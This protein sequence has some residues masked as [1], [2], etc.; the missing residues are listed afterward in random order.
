MK[1]KYKKFLKAAYINYEEDYCGNGS[2]TF[3]KPTIT[4]PVIVITGATAI[5]AC[6][7]NGATIYYTLDGSTP[8]SN[9][10]KYTGTITLTQSCVIKAIAVKPG[11]SDSAVATES[12]VRY[13][14]TWRLAGNSEVHGNEIWSCGEYNATDG[15]YHILIQPLRSS[16]VDITLKEP[17]RMTNNVVDNIEFVDGVGTVTRNFASCNL[18]DF[19]WVRKGTNS[20]GLYRYSTPSNVELLPNCK[21]VDN[22]GIALCPKYS[23]I[24]PNSTYTRNEGIGYYNSNN[25]ANGQIFI[26]D[27]NVN[28]LSADDFKD[29][30]QNVELIYQIAPIT[31]IIQ[32]PQI[33]KA[34]S[35]TCIISQSAKAVEWSSFETE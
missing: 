8:T 5:I 26:Y 6:A 1:C 14:T 15:K 31:E 24:I 23:V 16:I 9:S 22:L 3:T 13:L 29:Y 28:T 33:E 20:S 4:T 12:Y 17:L 25:L 18:G 34:D 35:Y 7:V 10:T 11:M 21:V 19:T 32:V 2:G 30:I 27:S